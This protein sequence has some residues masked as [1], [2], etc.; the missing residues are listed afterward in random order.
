MKQRSKGAAVLF[1]VLFLGMLVAAP[2]VF[3]Q[4]NATDIAIANQVTVNQCS[5]G[6]PVVLNG[7]LHVEYSVGTDP[8]S[9]A[10]LFSISASN[11]LNGVGRTTG[12][13]YAAADSGDYTVSSTQSSAEA[14]VEL[15]A[16][17]TPQ[18]SGTAMTLTQQL[19]ITVDT[20]GA[21]TVQVLGNTTSCGS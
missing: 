4:S 12:A 15:K 1:A 6:E 13:Q 18:G 21:L 11:N 5:A 10:N 14:T 17:M 20:A 19:H 2:A 16:D 8:S 9:G 7:T 3:A